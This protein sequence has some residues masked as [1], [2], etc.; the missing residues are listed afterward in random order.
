M[1]LYVV[2]HRHAAETCPARDPQMGPMLLQH[3]SPQNAASFGIAIQSEA[4]INGAH[5]LYMIVE[6]PSREPVDQFMAP[7]RQVGSVEVLDASPCEAV[8]ERGGCD[9]AS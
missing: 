4:V 2:Q 7:F 1:A 3:L 8:I 9:V 5:T 6:A